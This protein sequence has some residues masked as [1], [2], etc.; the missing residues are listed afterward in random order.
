MCVENPTPGSYPILTIRPARS[1]ALT[2]DF[3]LPAHI[4]AAPRWH[5]WVSACFTAA[6]AMASGV[7]MIASTAVALRRSRPAARGRCQGGLQQD[8]GRDGGVRDQGHG[9]CATAEAVDAP[10]AAVLV[11]LLARSTSAASRAGRRSA[12]SRRPRRSG[13]TARRARP[14]AT[15][16]MSRSTPRRSRRSRATRPRPRASR[17]SRRPRRS[18]RSWSRRTRRRRRSPRRPPSRPPRPPRTR[19]R[20]KRSRTG[21]PRPRRRRCRRRERW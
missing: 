21:T 11:G 4:D 12:A 15:S 20:T 16:P 8:S 1:L 5:L 7:S 9:S 17:P 13:S 18:P 10:D 6:L 2:F 14:S 3:I 19:S